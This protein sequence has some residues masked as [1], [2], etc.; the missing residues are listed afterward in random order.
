MTAYLAPRALASRDRA[1]AQ[2]TES[3][4]C[5]L[6]SRLLLVLFLAI[7][8]INLAW[9]QVGTCRRTGDVCVEGPGTRMI[10]GY[11]VTRDCWRYEKQY[12]CR[13][14]VLLGDCA[15]LATNPRCGLISGACVS[16]N[17]DGTCSLYDYRYQCQDSTARQVL[18]CGGQLFCMSGNCLPATS[19]PDRDFPQVV[20]A[21]EV[22]RQAGVYFDPVNGTLFRGESGHCSM[23]AFSNCCKPAGSS[24]SSN[25]AL[26]RNAGEIA[27]ETAAWG[28]HYAADSLFNSFGPNAMTAA[29]KSGLGAVGAD[30]AF[31]PTFSLYGFV[32]SFNA[33]LAVGAGLNTGGIAL[34]SMSIGN[35]TVF[36][37]FDPMSFAISIAMQMIISEL[38]NCEPD[39]QQLA[40]K[41]GMGLCHEVGTYC[42]GEVL[43]ACFRHR[44]GYCCFNSKLSRM[45]NEQGRQQIGKSW[46]TGENPQCTGF[47]TDEIQSLDFS[48]M[49]LSGFFGDI[50]FTPMANGRVGDANASTIDGQIQDYFGAS[51]RTQNYDAAAP[52]QPGQR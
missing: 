37:G 42:D 16:Q 19:Q 25:Y 10:S 33:P 14:D 26:M 20:T 49:D 47:T 38:T 11:P 48:R 31:N 39:E 23:T 41:V 28:T 29:M 13:S 21:M 32:A 6:V 52:W 44:R 15:A 50:R 17:P 35:S 45:L 46:G 4:P 18:D 2:S 27:G 24:D 1:A 5:V 36:F 3:Y 22:A 40:M 9:G 30:Y 7:S 43:G 51:R 12:V 34:G 8:A